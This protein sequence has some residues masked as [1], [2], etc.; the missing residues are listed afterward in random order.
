M[1]L[2][3]LV[4]REIFHRKLNFL[5]CVCSVAVAAAC[6]TASATLLRA[7]DIRGTQIL[8]AKE[9][10]TK[11]EMDKLEDD[12]RKITLK[13]GFN[14]LILPKGQSLADLYNSDYST[15]YMPEEYVTRL[16]ASDVASIQ[17]LLPV[18]QEKIKWPE[19][20]RT[21][22]LVGTRGEVPK[23]MGG[24]TKAM[25]NPVQPGSIILGYELYKSL[26]INKGDKIDFMGRPLT[27]ADCYEE[28]GTKDDITAWMNLKEAQQLLG[29]EGQL[30]GIFA[31]ECVCAADS[32]AKVREDIA[33]VL[34]D[35]QV[36]E[37]ASQTLARAEARQRAATAAK[38]SID[39]EKK[40]RLKLRNESEEFAAVLVPTMMIA[41]GIWIAFLAL[42]NV[43]ERRAE[44]GIL[45]AIGLRSRQISATFLGKAFLFGIAGGGLGWA[46]GYGIAVAWSKPLSPAVLLDGRLLVEC[47]VISL[48]LSLLASWIPAIV[49][50]QQQP[51]DILREA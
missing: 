11:V 47:V 23:K 25:L 26:K 7:H 15:K 18:L 28:R 44:I 5:L 1:S 38:Q 10:E 27:V 24:P 43:K 39:S 51:A 36:I 22:I 9:A 49:A 17:H 16:A 45:R 42:S 6:L 8:S 35:T 13:L 34:P 19:R 48:L 32:L 30:N 20:E 2:W 21:I 31:L 41:C 37:F 4:F 33:R 40:H 3:H 29:K 12:Y 46:V 14:V 50:A